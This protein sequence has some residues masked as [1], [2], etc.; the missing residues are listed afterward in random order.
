MVAADGKRESGTAVTET[1]IRGAIPLRDLPKLVFLVKSLCPE[2]G[3][4]GEFRDYDRVYSPAKEVRLPPNS[5]R[6][7][8]HLVSRPVPGRESWQ[9]YSLM[10]LGLP[11]R[12][13][14]PPVEK[15]PVT[16]I[17]VGSEMPD[18][19]TA[20]GCVMQF[21]YVRRG[22][23]SRTRKGL[24]VDVYVVEKPSTPGNFSNCVPIQTGEAHAVVDVIS[25]TG[26]PP[27]EL[28]AFMQ[29]LQPIVALRGAESGK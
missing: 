6:L 17:S 23:R 25:D 15:R 21:E 5:I 22:L 12:R 18:F 2:V 26:A 8:K 14:P 9:T 29:H 19:L 1:L 3:H 20:M 13:V 4:I 24:I 10:S 28:F 16:T 11:D 7:R 27:A